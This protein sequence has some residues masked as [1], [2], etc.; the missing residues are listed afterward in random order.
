[1]WPQA[2]EEC[3]KV[4]DIGEGGAGEFGLAQRAEKS[5]AVVVG[6]AVL[7]RQA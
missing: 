6:Q 3:A 5:M 2:N 4:V 7:A 1:M